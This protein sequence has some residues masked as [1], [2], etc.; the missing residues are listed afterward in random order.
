[1]SFQFANIETRNRVFLAPMSGVTDLPFR[2]IAYNHGA[3]LVV[4]EMVA[5]KELVQTRKDM[6]RKSG[7]ENTGAWIVQLAGREAE[8]MAQGAK[9]AAD[10]GCQAI[11]INMGC[12]ARR[13]TGSASGS[14]LMRNLDHA[15]QLVDA[16]VGASDVP[17][18]LKMRLGWDEKSINAAELAKRAEDAGVSMIIVHGRTRCQFY[19]GKADW[20][21]IAAVKQNV[22]I[23]VVANGDAK[24]VT[25][26]RQML[27]QS[28]ADAVM[29]GRGAYGRPWLIGELANQLDKGS[30]I[31]PLQLAGQ[32][33]VT[34]QLY[35][36]IL[37]FY[38]TGTGVKFARKH[39][40]WFLDHCVE[41][42][43]LASD[44]LPIWR[45]ALMQESDHCKVLD[46]F[47]EL[48]LQM[49]DRKVRAA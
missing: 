38:G 31:E 25:D 1:M 43:M 34:E 48:G 32:L 26:I 28:G 23:P 36:S 8:W 19:K 22:N 11:D 30:G 18:T 46:A 5:S 6:L 42:R 39:L 3:G 16:V 15:M 4:S 35:H 27:A 10:M 37:S 20:K 45:K 49:Q 21:A 29:I 9:V 33:A 47:T 24:T 2:Q 14:A 41:N 7:G 12:P 13:V 17:V 44:E 40:G